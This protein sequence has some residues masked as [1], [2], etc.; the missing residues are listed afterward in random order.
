CDDLGMRHV[1]SFSAE[2]HDLLRGEN[3]SVLRLFAAEFFDTIERGTRP[4]KAYAPVAWREFDYAPGPAQEKLDPGGKK[5]LVVTDSEDGQTNLIRMVERFRSSFVGDIELV[6]LHDVDI[7][8]PCLGC[9]QCGYDNHCVYEGK[10]GYVDFFNTKVKTADILVWAGT[11]RDRYLSSTWKLF[12]DRSFFNCHAPSLTGKQMGFIISGPL[13]QLQNLRQM[14]KGYAQ[15]QHANL[16]GF[17]TDEFGDSAGIDDS[18][19]DLARRLTRLA[20]TGYAS[21]HTFLGVGGEKVLRDA[22]WGRLRF[23][24]RAD[25]V[26]YRR[27]GAFDFPQKEWKSRI[28]NGLML[29]LSKFPGFR[30]EVN[31]RM[32]SEMIK[33]FRKVLED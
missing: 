7:K 16:G 19:Q 18:L 31:K 2:T 6:N 24:F 17:V 3:R 1:G 14:L 12:L 11:I 13:S 4:P 8:G 5:V 10:D 27:S 28:Q 9:I 32:K 29:F 20:D 25:F 26:A 22:I 30:K 21:P 33:P 23:P 15:F